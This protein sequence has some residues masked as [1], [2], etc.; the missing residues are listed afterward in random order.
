[1]RKIRLCTAIAA[2]ALALA[3]GSAGL[4]NAGVSPNPDYTNA[5]H[6]PV[7]GYYAEGTDVYFTHLE[8]YIGLQDDAKNLTPAMSPATA[9]NGFGDQLCDSNTG[10]ALQVGALYN[11][12]GTFNVAYGYGTFGAAMTNQDPCEN[13]L[14]ARGL[15]GIKGT[16]LPVTGSIP[17]LA[18]VPYGDTI[19]VQVL[20]TPST[21]RTYFVGTIIGSN[22]WWSS[23]DFWLPAHL[24]LNESAAGVEGDTTGLSAPAVNQLDGNAH[25]TMSGWFNGLSSHP[26]RGYADTSSYWTA[27]PV[28]STGTGNGPASQALLRP[29]AIHDGN[30]S[31]YAGTPT[32]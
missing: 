26:V 14:I 28:D 19:E 22:R 3:L 29:G 12:D 7:A 16:G 21:G 31:I 18:H 10:Q 8:S 6:N 20:Y 15:T 27:V 25:F 9:T 5:N 13:G 23:P 11:G 2:G 17:Q 4:A 32:G 24:H 30:F 1:M